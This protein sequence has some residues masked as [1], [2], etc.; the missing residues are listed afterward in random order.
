MFVDRPSSPNGLLLVCDVR[1][2]HDRDLQASQGGQPVMRHWPFGV[3]CLGKREWE[4]TTRV[5]LYDYGED[6]KKVKDERVT[7]LKDLLG[8]SK[9]GA[10]AVLQTRSAARKA[11][12]KDADDVG[13]ALHLTGT[14]CWQAMKAP[15]RLPDMAGCIW[16]T[17]WGPT[18][19]VL[20]PVNYEYVY[21][22]LVRRH[23]CLALHAAVNGDPTLYVEA[24]NYKRDKA[25]YDALCQLAYSASMGR[26][27][28]VDIESN[29][30]TNALTAIGFSDGLTIVSMN[31]D[32]YRIFRSD[33]VEAGATDKEL[34]A[35]QQ[36]LAENCPKLFHNYS[37]DVPELRARGWAV[38]GSLHDT[39]AMHATVYKQWP[40]GLQKACAHEL[41]V[42]PWKSEYKP[43]YA[44]KYGLTRNDAGYWTGDPLKLR[45][46]NGQ[47]SFYTWHLG[48]AL[49]SKVGIQL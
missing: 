14:H 45:F 13:D 47:D 28:A 34:V 42:P 22:E 31:V 10:V 19:G 2:K 5:A 32:P 44:K 12:K 41:P 21:R 20:N 36:L 38:N 7:V 40:H 9:W 3:Q 18:I 11:D 43:E 26:S 48:R 1:L 29:P 35:I 25:R 33:A 39:M 30:E 15:D 23:L 37:F 46:Y 27:I 16:Q 6:V 49:A 8:T 24:L 17:S 4:R